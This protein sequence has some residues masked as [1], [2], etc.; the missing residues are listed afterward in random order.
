MIFILK[1]EKVEG[2]WHAKP[3]FDLRIVWVTT[4]QNF[5]FYSGTARNKA[6]TRLEQRGTARNKAPIPTPHQATVWRVMSSQ[7]Y[8]AY[9]GLKIFP[10]GRK[11]SA[12]LWEPWINFDF[13]IFAQFCHGLSHLTHNIAY[14][15]MVTRIIR[16]PTQPRKLKKPV[17]ESVTQL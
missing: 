12:L 11:H 4:I 13:H 3:C 2:L 15:M 1:L 7:Q 10:I 5:S 6:G 16:K 8:Q 14:R 9:C 17:I